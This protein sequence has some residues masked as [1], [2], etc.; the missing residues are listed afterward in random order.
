[1]TSEKIIENIIDI[2][3]PA[4]SVW[5]ALV[6]PEKTKQYMY[7]CAAESIWEVGSELLWR[8]SYEGQD[9]IFVIGHV[10]AYDPPHK[11]VYT[12]FDPNSPIDD[13]PENYLTV[14]YLL[15]EGNGKTTLTVT[16]GDYAKVADGERR[17][18]ESL[19]HGEGWN[20]I[21][22]EIKRIVEEG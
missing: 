3:A 2:N 18:N 10:I 4:I 1:M 21:L 20:P 6:N 13:I 15:E 19:N 14:T 17:Y 11:L 5:D 16:Q 7:G 8:G 22:K 9:T 12:T